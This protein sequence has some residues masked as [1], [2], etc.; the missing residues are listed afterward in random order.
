MNK[1]QMK[2]LEPKYTGNTRRLT[3]GEAAGIMNDPANQM[4][5]DLLEDIPPVALIEI[6][7]PE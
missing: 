3:E 6:N 1:E 4:E 5:D 2:A 7:R